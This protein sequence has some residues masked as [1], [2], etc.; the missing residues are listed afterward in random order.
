[1]MTYIETGLPLQVG[2]VLDVDKAFWG[3]GQTGSRCL[4]MT[5]RRSC[6]LLVFSN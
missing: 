5:H 6:K 3:E 1:M 4:S 2:G